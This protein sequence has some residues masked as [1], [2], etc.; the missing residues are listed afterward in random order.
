MTYN[1]SNKDKKAISEFNKGKYVSHEVGIKISKSR[2]DK[3]MGKNNDMANPENRKK[4]GLSKIGR[5]KLTHE[6]LPN[7]MIHAS[8]VEWY[9]LID[10]WYKIC[11]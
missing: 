2:K 9:K 3:G 6:S 11:Q 4:V 1:H 7:R 10:Q 8:S 5:K